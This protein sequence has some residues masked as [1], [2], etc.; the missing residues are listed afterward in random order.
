MCGRHAHAGIVAAHQGQAKSLMTSTSIAAAADVD[1]LQRFVCSCDARRTPP[2]PFVRSRAALRFSKG[3]RQSTPGSTCQPTIRTPTS[4]YI[5]LPA[6]LSS[7]L[8]PPSPF[9][10]FRRT[11]L[12]LQQYDWP[13]LSMSTCYWLTVLASQAIFIPPRMARSASDTMREEG[14]QLA[15]TMYT[16]RRQP[17]TIGQALVPPPGGLRDPSVQA[18]GCDYL[19]LLCNFCAFGTWHRQPSATRAVSSLRFRPRI[20][21]LE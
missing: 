1:M 21:F 3:T 18:R 19:F 5:E 10:A 11:K 16:R 7:L 13:N 17:A 8:P 20:E 12:P 15:T 4:N 14:W 9:E 2:T 6:P